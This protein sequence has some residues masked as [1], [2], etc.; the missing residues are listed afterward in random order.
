MPPVRH[1]P[2]DAAEVGQALPGGR[3]RGTLRA[4]PSAEELAG[5]EGHGV[6]GIGDLDLRRQRK[7]GARRILNELL[8]LHGARLS[9]AT[10]HKVL[11]QHRVR[12][13]SRRRRRPRPTHYAKAIPGERVQLDTCKIARRRFQY[14]AV[15][16]CTRYQVLG[17]FPARNAVFTLQ[18]LERLV[19]ETPFPIQRVQ[20]D[21]GREFFATAVQTRLAALGI[22]CRPF[23]PASPHLNGKVERAQKTD[24][25]EFWSTVD[26]SDRDLVLRLAEWQHHYNWERPHGGLGGKTP[27]ERYFELAETT[28][29]W[30]EVHAAYR[31][32]CER[33]QEAND[34]LD[35]RLRRVKP[36]P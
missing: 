20:T 28:P 7:L 34:Q 19:E 17:L 22:K 30:S 16:D 21:R 36:S 32:G 8:R 10:I 15:D 25:D 2:T 31:W 14:T 33:I 9:L 27:M 13:L 11:T 29:L 12:P 4:F 26:V 5:Q 18:F 24:L 1:Q 23:R 6:A 3:A 35:Q